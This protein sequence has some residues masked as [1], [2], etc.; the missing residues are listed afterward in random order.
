MELEE[1]KPKVVTK[2]SLS[3]M[4]TLICNMEDSINLLIV[5][6]NW[7]GNIS[8]RLKFTPTIQE[9]ENPEMVGSEQPKIDLISRLESIS[10]NL[11]KVYSSIEKKTAKLNQIIV[12]KK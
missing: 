7:L 6:D 4:E 2:S 8:D 11:A 10:I 12:E 5:T 9:H 1:L 3:E